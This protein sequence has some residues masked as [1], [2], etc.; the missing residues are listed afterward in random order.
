M[1]I[2]K[3]IGGDR[4]GAGKKMKGE[5][6]N[7]ERS[8]H[9]LSELFQTSIASGVLY[10]AYVNQMLPGDVFEFNVHSDARTLPTIGP[11]FG[12]F[13]LQ[14]DFFF[15]A[16]RLYNAR[17][18]NNPI[19]VGMQMQNIKLPVA[20]FPVL[21]K[22]PDESAKEY[23]ERTKCNTSSLP[24][25]LGYSGFGWN[26]NKS[27]E[28]D[29]SPVT[30]TLPVIN[31]LSYYDIFKNYYA[32]KQEDDF[33]YI[34]NVLVPNLENSVFTNVYYYNAEGQPGE[35]FWDKDFWYIKDESNWPHFVQDSHDVLFGQKFVLLVDRKKLNG[36]LVID[37]INEK[38]QVK[39]PNGS[40]HLVKDVTK[41][42]SLLSGYIFEE[43]TPLVD[44]DTIAL[45]NIDM[46][47]YA[48]I[49]FQFNATEQQELSNGNYYIFDVNEFINEVQ[50]YNQSL[51]DIDN[52]R[53]AIL[54]TSRD[55]VFNLSSFTDDIGFNVFN[56]LIISYL[57]PIPVEEYNA[58]SKFGYNLPMQGLICKT[59][60]NDIFNTWL[61]KEFIEGVDSIAEVTKIDTTNGLYMDAL[62]LAEKV[63]NMKCQIAI[64]GGTWEDWQ[65]AAYGVRAIRRAETPIYCGGQ[66][67]VISFDEVVSNSATDISGDPAPLGTLGGRGKLSNH[68]G[69]KVVI[70]AREPGVVMAIVSL[71][72]LDPVYVQGNKWFNTELYSPDD[73][74]KPALDAIG[75]QD[76]IGEQMSWTDTYFDQGAWHRRSYGKLP[77]WMN[78]MTSVGRAAGDFADDRG[79]SF[80]V[81]SRT[82]DINSD[83]SIADFTAYIDPKKFNYMFAYADRDAQNFWVQIYFDV[84]A[85]RKMSAKLIPNL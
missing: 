9:N 63:Y 60:Q 35:E 67:A 41:S 27:A 44:S 34:E 16:D 1:G 65:E 26:D 79:K 31:F 15:I 12:A 20:D 40:V 58:I 24:Y 33:Y 22:L 84:K 7:Y 50:L 28:Q 13:K 71:T 78:Y 42:Q 14:I 61:S 6:R 8:T 62:N 38:I 59:Y 25:Y 54:M 69:G 23:V 53:D 52:L 70:K 72:P 48:P 80:M 29:Y 56:S 76:L 55:S 17:L 36:G 46:V 83:G 64:S 10:P 19:K 85:R 45:L 74:H 21:S 2:V 73:F 11:M 66:S 4:L 57:D 82:Y 51:E 77:A 47:N 49:V 3:T 81:L 5:L 37:Y 68:R 18:H 32:N 39:L 30:R 43:F 75:F